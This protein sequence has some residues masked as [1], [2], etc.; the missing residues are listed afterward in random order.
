MYM[1]RCPC[2]RSKARGTGNL[3]HLSKSLPPLQ[4]SCHRKST[5]VPM[6]GRNRLSTAPCRTSDTNSRYLHP[7]PVPEPRRCVTTKHR[8]YQFHLRTGH[9]LQIWSLDQLSMMKQRCQTHIQVIPCSVLPR[10]FITG[11]N[12]PGLL[13]KWGHLRK[14]W[15]H[16]R[17]ND[18]TVI[19]RSK[20][21]LH[22]Y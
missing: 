10:N 14:K 13:K 15:G 18:G 8:T 1:C 17:K 12:V 5:V 11:D 16:C 6:R 20:I 7:N 2:I 21:S 22:H 4:P 3:H 9:I 19:W